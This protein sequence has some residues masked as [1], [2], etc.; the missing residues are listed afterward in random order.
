MEQP[1]YFKAL[2]G[3]PLYGVYHA[4][5]RAAKRALPVVIC[6]SLFEERKSAYAPLRRLALRLQAAGHSV[7]RFDYRGSGE[8]GG[9][10][11]V[12]R[13]QHLREDVAVARKTLAK[14]AGRR[15]SILLGL[16][17]GAT[18]ALQETQRV[19]GESVIALAPIVKGAAQVRLWKMRSKIR[20]ELTEG[21]G[22]GKSREGG[23]TM[24]FDGYELHP[25]FF[26]DV[27]ALDLI[28]EAGPLSCPSRIVQIAHK[29]EALADTTQLMIALGPRAKLE[30]LKMEP[31]WDKLDDV[32]TAPL[33]EMVLKG[34]NDI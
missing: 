2:D 29:T 23:G 11:A 7:L 33:E 26:D 15:D 17:L 18:L 3:L 34:L 20:A 19:G 14:L 22:Q 6:P 10:G 31:F 5:E 12:R 16:R 27:A 8:S 30:V 32:D 21:S 28:K 24:D 9:Q 13:W 25:S 4:P 1:G